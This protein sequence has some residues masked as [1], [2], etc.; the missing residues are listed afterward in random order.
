MAF[1]SMQLHQAQRNNEID[2]HKQGKQIS[3]CQLFNFVKILTI[4][5]MQKTLL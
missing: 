5:Q 2:N 3:I 4:L 1:F